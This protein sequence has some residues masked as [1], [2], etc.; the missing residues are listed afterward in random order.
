MGRS[1]PRGRTARILLV[2]D[3]A[4]H[5]ELVRRGLEAQSIPSELV[6]LADG[7]RALDYLFRAA[8]FEA[9][10]GAPLPDLVLLDLNL[11][12]VA[13]LQVLRRLRRAEQTRRLPVV[14]LTTSSAPSDTRGAYDAL[15]NGYLVKPS[16]YPAYKQLMKDI[17]GYWLGWNQV[18]QP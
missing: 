3:D 14:V 5:A 2:E 11:P 10:Q 18:V 9:L 15:A 12:K 1:R 17:C 8:E 16:G 13:G 7:Q 6:H 4:E